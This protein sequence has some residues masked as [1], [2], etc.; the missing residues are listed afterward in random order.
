VTT[1]NA[2]RM[3]IDSS[4]NVGIG[5][6]DPQSKLQVEHSDFARLDLNLSDSSGT[7]IAD[8]RGLV[9]GTEKWRIGKTGSS[10]DDFTFNVTGSERMRIESSG[11]VRIQNIKNVCASN[12]RDLLE[13]KI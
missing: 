12:L 6:N 7:T 1:N 2:E 8:V 4:G 5:T 13:Y 10:S 9:S 3:R 11:L